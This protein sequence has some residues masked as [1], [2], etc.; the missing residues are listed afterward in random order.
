MENLFSSLSNTRRDS[1]YAECSFFFSF[2][3]AYWKQVAL[4][5][6]IVSHLGG[7]Y[8]HLYSQKFNL[9]QPY[10]KGHHEASFHLTRF[11]ATTGTTTTATI[12]ITNKHYFKVLDL[13]SKSSMSSLPL[14]IPHIINQLSPIAIIIVDFSNLCKRCT[15]CFTFINQHFDALPYN[16]P[17]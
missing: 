11:S 14:V 16:N 13:H 12:T 10:R 5:L 1:F 9:Y 6:A 2:L 8:L 17:P 3:S 15:Q 7:K 4:L